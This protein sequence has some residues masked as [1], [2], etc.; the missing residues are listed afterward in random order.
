M[1]NISEEN[2]NL[3]PLCGPYSVSVI[4]GETIND[5]LGKWKKTFNKGA[6]WKGRST[7]KECVS[8]IQKYGF[9]TERVPVKCS[10]SRFIKDH[11]ERSKLYFIRVG[12]HFLCL[13]DGIIID[14]YQW[15]TIENHHAKRKRVTDVYEVK[16]P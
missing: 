16:K 2:S 7:K 3:Y 13:T 1:R 10:L 11:M 9:E 15:D 12:G 4:C 5:M 8:M 6:N 14:Q